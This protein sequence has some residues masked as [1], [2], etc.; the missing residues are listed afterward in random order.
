MTVHQQTGSRG[1]ERRS[2]S[3]LECRNF[4]AAYVKRSDQASRRLIRYLSMQSHRVLL[5]VR[6]AKTGQI[7]ISPPKEELW[8]VREKRGIGRAVKNSWKV[9]KQLNAEF[10]EEIDTV[11][12]WNLG[13]DDYYDI[14]VWDNAAGDQYRFL[15]T[16]VVE[17]SHIWAC[18]IEPLCFAYALTDVIQSA[19]VSRFCGHLQPCGT[20]PAD[21]D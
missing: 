19:P 1:L 6:D 9:V 20:N 15:Y 10:F 3:V 13:F 5:L 11:R 8:L 18:S 14:F 12:K 21:T 16:T 2:H 4:I 7:L 17:V